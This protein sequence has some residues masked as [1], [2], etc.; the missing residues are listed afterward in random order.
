MEVN[1]LRVRID[2]SQAKKEAKSINASLDRMKNRGKVA[3]AALAGVAAGLAT[4]KLIQSARQF[5]VLNAQLETA[6]GSAQ[7]ASVAF[8]AIKEFAATTPFDLAQVT[9]GFVKLVNLGLDPSERALESYGN[10]A[11]AMGK[12]L[13]QL[14]EAVAN[15][16]TGELENL[17][18]FGIKARNQGDTIAFTFRGV[19]K[20]V[21]NE[22][23]EIEGYLQSLGENEFSGAMQRRAD[24]L[25]GALSNLGDTWDQL[26]FT[27]ANAGVG[28]LIEGGV[29]KAT[30]A[31]QLLIDL[32][33][34]G[35]LTAGFEAAAISFDGYG[36]DIARTLD[37]IVGLFESA[38]MNIDEIGSGSA[39]GYFASF[40]NLPTDFRALIQKITVSFAANLDAISAKATLFSE[41]VSAV[42]T[43]A[44]IADAQK[45]YEERIALITKV[46]EDSITTIE[47]ERDATV[48]ATKQKV[49]E[50]NELFEAYK[51]AREE[52]EKG[53]RLGQFRAT[54][55]GKT[56][57]DIKKENELKKEAAKLTEKL[58]TP[59]EKYNKQLERLNEL[60][61]FLAIDTFKRAVK[62]YGEELNKIPELREELVGIKESLLSEEQALQE[63]Y[64]SRLKIVKKALEQE[65]IAETEAQQL[66]QQL[67]EELEQGLT[68]TSAA[69]DLQNLVDSL[70]TQEEAI[71]QSYERR[72]EILNNALEQKLIDEQ[73]YAELETKLQV[74]RDNELLAS[75]NRLAAAQIQVAENVAGALAAVAKDGS[76]TQRALLAAEKAGAVAR[77]LI[78]LQEAIAKA[79]ALGFPQNIPAIAQ[80]TAAGG[81]AVA[82]LRSVAIPQAH[83]GLTSV[84]ERE[85]TYLLKQGERVVAP[86]QNEDLTNFLRN[87]QPQ[88]AAGTR[89]VNLT[90]PAELLGAL[91]NP[92]GE[93]IIIN[94]ISNNPERINA[95]LNQAA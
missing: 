33:D 70:M 57:A 4:R 34:S 71:R 86:K 35:A 64:D 90:D 53:D 1:S 5:D 66:K 21:A 45:K 32:I 87:Q 65:L 30:E 44:T 29:R 60:K 8:D 69:T 41:S 74:D 23:S 75:R 76:K 91:Q 26:F 52:R 77:A 81:Q 72:R 79:N 68:Q 2:G 80:A 49:I 63:S 56:L 85:Q 22:A 27:I 28:D 46:Y 11:S 88:Q 73:R 59:Q 82:A 42:F 31:I 93:E 17:K 58:L 9:E 92:E 78:A 43:D 40:Q 95:L 38:A 13:N 12:S 84:P 37:I 20:T 18:K 51:K 89:V 61:P 6:T 54:G 67:K 47:E 62:E 36:E 55:S 24:T 3:A 19:T 48:K 25:D 10:T 39:D 7:G 15:A 83:A 14:I 94:A 50:A 16:A